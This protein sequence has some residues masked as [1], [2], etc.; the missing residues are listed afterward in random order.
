MNRG[1][2]VLALVF[3]ASCLTISGCGTDRSLRHSH[4]QASPRSQVSAS[5]A[6]VDAHA[7]RRII[8]SAAVDTRTTF[9]DAVAQMSDQWPTPKGQVV[10]ARLQSVTKSRS[11]RA[12]EIVV[13][14]RRITPK[15]TSARMDVFRVSLPIRRG[16]AHA[17][18]RAI[19]LHTRVAARINISRS[20]HSR[21]A[22][23]DRP[24]ARVWDLSGVGPLVVDDPSHRQII[25]PYIDSV[26][27]VYNG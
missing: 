27:G 20:A 6:G 10:Q 11:H 5:A 12:T 15:A 23:G 17:L 26:V 7:V 22:T 4:G 19:P 2:I 21:D 3:A 25:L 18:A 8:G 1:V 13:T 9:E 16:D 14:L 24:D